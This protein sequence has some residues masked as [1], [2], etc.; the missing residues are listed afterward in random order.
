MSYTDQ[1]LAEMLREGEADLVERKPSPADT[2]D[3]RKDICAFANDLPGHQKSGVVFV[4][5]YDNGHCANLKVTDQILQNLAHLRS[6]GQITPFPSLVVQ[7]RVLNG[8][9]MAVIM[10]SPSA[11][12]PVRY[13]GR[14]WIRVGTRR[15][16]ASPEEEV[17]LSERRRHKDLPFDLRSVESAT[18]ADLDLTLFQRRYLA[19]AVAPEVIEQNNRSLADQLKALRM[20]TPDEEPTVLGCLVLAKEPTNFIGGAYV[21]FLRIDGI[22]LGDAIQDAERITGPLPDLMDRLDAKLEAHITTGVDASSG[23]TEVRQPTYPLGALRQLSRNAILHRTYESTNAPVRV[24]W[25]KDRI[26][27]ISPGGVYGSVTPETF[28]QPGV[29]DYRNLH[30]AEAMRNLGYVQKF[31]MGI[32]LARAELRKNANPD[33]QFDIKPNFICCIL[34]PR[35]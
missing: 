4:G 14:C 2:G 8:C 23:P 9:E 17:R 3:I 19:A 20:L 12:P 32:A 15:D 35:K 1:E 18:V 27:I 30:L 24:T 10:V 21:Q 7:R 33:V 28:G 6:D 13:N 22:S 25:Y 29:A 34:Q 5:V 16:T 31:G 26:E 11:S